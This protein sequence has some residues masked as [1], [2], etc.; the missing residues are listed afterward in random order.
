VV[1]VEF[2]FFG[3]EDDPCFSTELEEFPDGRDVAVVVGGVN[4]VLMILGL[5]YSVIK[6]TLPSFFSLFFLPSG[7]NMPFLCPHM[8]CQ[9]SRVRLSQA[10][11]AS[12]QS[13]TDQ[14]TVRLCQAH[15]SLTLD[16]SPPFL[17]HL[18][19]HSPSRSMSLSFAICLSHSVA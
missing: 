7:Y 1:L 6:P 15:S 19:C 13:T 14:T 9:K 16:H 17:G 3:V 10:L 2:A 4:M 18:S 11:P 12:L 8:T 5:L